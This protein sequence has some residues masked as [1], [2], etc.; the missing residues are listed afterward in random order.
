MNSHN[1]TSRFS[2]R[3]DAYV[4]YRPT[5]PDELVALITRET[6]HGAGARVADIGSGTGISS[7]LLLRHGMEVYAVEP[8]GAM[9]EAAER[10][11]GENE[12]FHSIEGTAEETGLPDDSVDLVVAAQAFHWFDRDRARAEFD[13]I[14][15]PDGAIVLVWN[16]RR[17][18]GSDFLVEYEAL[19]HRF[20]T[21]YAQINHRNVDEAQVAAFFG[22]ENHTVHRLF[23]EQ[24]VDFDGAKGRLDSSSYVPAPD[25]PHYDAMIAELKEVFERN[26][27]EGRV[28]IVYDVEVYIGRRGQGN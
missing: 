23:N 8:N 21:D 28:G 27:E 10:M 26:A 25:H 20:G 18:E 3:V 22:S 2:D 12:R 16:S 17:T 11:L 19:L 6:G 5:Y 7:D 24:T 9:R 14:L 4:R 15:R 13:R 1:S